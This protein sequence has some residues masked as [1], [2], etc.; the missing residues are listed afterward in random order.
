MERYLSQ[1][2]TTE[3]LPSISIVVPTYNSARTLNECLNSLLIQDYP[4]EKIEIIIADG[5]SKDS[6]LTLAR[7]FSVAKVIKN[8]LRTGE[9][10]K[11]VGAAIAKNEIIAFVDSDNILP[12]T[13]W[14]RR[15]VEAF[16]DPNIIA[17]E[18]LY[19]TYRQSDPMITRYCA[20]TGMNDI[21][22]L[23][24]G[25]YDRY[26]YLTGKW[27]GLS[28][29][30]TEHTGY[31]EVELENDIPTIGANGFLIRKQVLDSLNFRP[32][33]FDIDIVHQAVHSG[34]NKFAK[35]KIGIVH[36][37]ASST[38]SYIR[39]TRRRISEYLFYHQLGKRKYQW[40]KAN[41]TG[42]LKFICYTLL[43]SPLMIQIATGYTKKPD[44]AWFFHLVA[45]WITLLVYSSTYLEVLFRSIVRR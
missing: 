42:F 29:K 9:A 23:F 45:C 32:Y 37:F 11:A 20:L 8:P 44:R 4:K 41:R 14:L 27:T 22:C 34:H 36:L 35:T 30:N 28:I 26:C 18:P 13:H 25:N 21:L 15:M 17:S 31:L 33:L 3:S 10:G 6:T 1:H 19:Y 5:G 12:T 38:S 2:K 39:K 24:L 7:S 43:S 40:Q 16:L